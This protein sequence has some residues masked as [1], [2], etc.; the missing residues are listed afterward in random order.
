[1]PGSS[2]FG[3]ITVDDDGRWV[4]TLRGDANPKD[5]AS[6]D[7]AIDAILAR[8]TLACARIPAERTRRYRELMD[9]ARKRG[10]E[11]RFDAY[12]LLVQELEAIAL[13]ICKRANPVPVVSS[14]R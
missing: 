11:A 6:L 12:R 9:A 1:M 4:T 8:E 13:E 10:D 2:Y 3:N 7:D 14:P 5:Y